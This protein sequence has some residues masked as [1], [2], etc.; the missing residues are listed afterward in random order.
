MLR[1]KYRKYITFS[2][3]IKKQFDNDNT[4]TYKLEF[5][6]SFRLQF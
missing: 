2:A 3:P 1:R 6:G 4:V 5:S